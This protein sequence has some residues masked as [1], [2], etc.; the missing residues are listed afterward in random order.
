MGWIP[1]Y[2]PGLVV[3]VVLVVGGLWRST[4]PPPDGGDATPRV[5]AACTVTARGAYRFP[6]VPSPTVA[7]SRILLAL[8]VGACLLCLGAVV[9]VI[10]VGPC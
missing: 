6:T 8:A 5:P 2:F 3:L 1:Y 9:F 10:V 7:W 4:T